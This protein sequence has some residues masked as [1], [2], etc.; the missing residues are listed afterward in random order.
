MGA[1]GIRGSLFPISIYIVIFTITS[2][3]SKSS[4]L[5]LSPLFYV[6]AILTLLAL[7]W[8]YFDVSALL[9]PSGLPR[10]F[11]LHAKMTLSNICDMDICAYWKIMFDDILALFQ[12]HVYFTLML[13]K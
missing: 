8:C 13:F 11:L 5:P 4:G 10:T 9:R 1:V 7:L 6:G 12:C 2:F 3:V